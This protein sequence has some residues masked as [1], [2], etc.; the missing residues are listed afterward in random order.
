MAEDLCNVVGIQE[1]S[2]P[3]STQHSIMVDS[4]KNMLMTAT[5]LTVVTVNY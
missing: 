1:V 2:Y 4:L 3:V 5:P